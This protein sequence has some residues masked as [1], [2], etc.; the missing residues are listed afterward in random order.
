MHIPMRMHM[1]I[2]MPIHM[3]ICKSILMTI[4]NFTQQVRSQTGL[5]DGANLIAGQV[6]TMIENQF[7]NS[8]IDIGSDQ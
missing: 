7:W 6:V 2:G 3:S 8:E 1:S 5:F 4:C